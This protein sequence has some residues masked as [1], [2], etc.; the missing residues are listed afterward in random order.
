MG[1]AATGLSEARRTET[2]PGWRD[3]E[4]ERVGEGGVRRSLPGDRAL[5]ALPGRRYGNQHGCHCHSFVG[6]FLRPL[7]HLFLFLLFFLSPPSLLSFI[8]RLSSS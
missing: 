5:P 7:P 6:L 1:T 4:Q 2:E 3:V 8:S